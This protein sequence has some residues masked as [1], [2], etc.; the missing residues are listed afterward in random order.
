MIDPIKC[1][2]FYDI[3]I[4]NNIDFFTG[5]P[6]SLLKNFCSYMTDNTT[7]EKNIIA[8]NEGNAI[9]LAAGYNL[10]T[11]KFGLVYMQNS[12]EGNAINPLTSLTDPDVYSIPVLLLIG[13]R[14]EPGIKDEPQHKKMGKITLKLLDTLGI[15]YS[16]LNK[17]YD[18]TIKTAID[19][20]KKNKSPYALI[21]K[22]GIFS[23][24]KMRDQIN[25]KFELNREG[26]LKI[27]VPILETND[28]IVSTTGK[29]S[30]ELFELRKSLGMDLDNDFLTVGSMGH[31]SSIALGIALPKSD[32]NVYCFDGDGALI[33]HMGALSIIGQL[34]PKNLK[35]IV[36][37]NYAHDSVGGQPTSSKNINI[38]DIA[39]ANGYK[40][41]YSVNSKE[42]LIE[43]INMIKDMDGPILLEIKINKG[44]R[45]NLGRPTSSPIEN[46][47]AFVKNLNNN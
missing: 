35:H 20:M 29:T 45:E 34:S 3:L 5:V 39:L 22:K 12:G 25:F 47:E 11:S 26:A 2:Q 18:N 15:P 36:F 24:Y 30:R 33:M 41:A 46:K 13:W 14:G 31:S 44:A 42:Q 37:N 7:P 23:E 16:I 4:E 17:D 38:P 28:I 10:A 19:H 32:K 21:A 43:K 6:D 40:N 1:N 9:A 8:A 27:I